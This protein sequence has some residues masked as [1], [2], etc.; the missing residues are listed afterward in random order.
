MLR[1]SKKPRSLT[2]AKLLGCNF[3]LFQDGKPGEMAGGK[4]LAADSAKLDN[5]GSTVQ[6]LIPGTGSTVNEGLTMNP[7][8]FI[9]NGY[10]HNDSRSY[11]FGSI[12]FCWS[13]M[14]F[15]T[16]HAFSLSF[17]DKPL[18]PSNSNFRYYAFPLRC[19]HSSELKIRKREKGR[20]KMVLIFLES[21]L[22]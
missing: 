18:Y 7:L 20:L 4:P 14:S 13:A 19:L 16:E 6:T 8:Y 1:S 10:M 9:R 2:G 5:G 12:A 21:V 22:R 17:Y 11:S 15:S 3:N